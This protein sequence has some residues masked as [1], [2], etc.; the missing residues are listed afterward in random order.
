MW[1]STFFAQLKWDYIIIRLGYSISINIDDNVDKIICKKTKVKLSL[2][3]SW[4]PLG[5]WEVEAPTF[6]DIQLTDS[7]KVVSPM[8]QPLFTPQEDSWY[9]FLLEAELTPGP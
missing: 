6:S 7:G 2:Y 9:S 5:L 8:R 3:R 1:F 4:K